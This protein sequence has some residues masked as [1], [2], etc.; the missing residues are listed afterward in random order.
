MMGAQMSEKLYLRIGEVADLLGVESHMLRYWEREFSLKPHRSNAG[1]RL[2]RKHE[3][4]I[5]KRIK[6]L[7]LDEGYT[8]TGAKKVMAGHVPIGEAVQTRLQ[9]VSNRLNLLHK[10]IA[11]LR[12]NNHSDGTNS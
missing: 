11:E 10:H 12:E 1:Q 8:L 4:N 2:Y 3:I 5:L 6:T 9:E 7:V